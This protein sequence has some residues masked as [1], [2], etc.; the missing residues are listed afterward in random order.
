M[1]FL[2]CPKCKEVSGDDWR[3]CEGQCPMTRSPHYDQYVHTL[4]GE[5]RR[6]DEAELN[7]RYVR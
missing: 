2:E 6:I 7:A 1:T 5:P 4:Y 3:Q